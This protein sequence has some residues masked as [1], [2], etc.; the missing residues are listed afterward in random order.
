M[1]RLDSIFGDNAVCSLSIVLPWQVEVQLGAEGRRRGG[2][3]GDGGQDERRNTSGE[4]AAALQTVRRGD[5]GEEAA[6]GASHE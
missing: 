5:I 2:G 3:G 4:L 6:A 1:S